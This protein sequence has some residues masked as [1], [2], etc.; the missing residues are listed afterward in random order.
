MEPLPNT[1]LTIVKKIKKKL[2]EVK[3]QKDY[4]YVYVYRLEGDVANRYKVGTTKREPKKRLKEWSN[5]HTLP[6]ITE[7]IWE[8]PVGCKWVERMI[9]LYL[10][11]YR[12]IRYELDSGQFTDYMYANGTPTVKG[13]SMHRHVEWFS[14]ELK[15]I[16]KW[17][18]TLID[19][20]VNQRPVQPGQ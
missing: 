14:V 16:E 9:H 4:G 15:V 10:D 8:V 12:L 20:I 5:I 18:E 17:V 3:P 7:I 19:F 6:L 2:K 13:V 11:P 1:R